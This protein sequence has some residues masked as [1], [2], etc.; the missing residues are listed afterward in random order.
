MHTCK[1]SVCEHAKFDQDWGEYKCK[2]FNHRI[3]DLEKVE[4]CEGY[5]ALY[6]DPALIKKAKEKKS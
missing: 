1:C 4:E 2:K 5:K 3:Y 6:I